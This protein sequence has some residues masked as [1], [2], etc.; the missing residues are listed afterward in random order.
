MSKKLI[1]VLVIIIALAGVG[2]Y[3]RDNISGIVGGGQEARF[4]NTAQAR[5][6]AQAAPETTTIRPA[7]NSSQVSAAGNIEIANQLPAVLQLEGLVAEVLVEV[8]DEVSAGDL[9]VALDTTD[10]ERA[11]QR[12]ELEFDVRQ[13]Q[14]DKLMEPSDVADIAAARANLASAKENLDEV[15]AGPTDSEIAAAEASLAAAQERYQEL[16]DGQS[17]AELIQVSVELHKA[18]LTLQQA[19]EAYDEIAYRDDI[20]SS[21]QAMDLQNATIDYEA[22]KAAYE[23]A[24]EPA[25][26]AD[27]QDALKSIRE[28]EQ[29][30]D[31][32]LNQP[33]D[34]EIAEAEAKVVSTEAELAGLLSGPSASDVREAELNLQQAQ[35]DLE[36]A[37]ANLDKARLRAPIAGTILAV[38]V[39][40][41]QKISGGLEALSLA[42][43][44]ELELTVNVAEV[45]VRKVREGQPAKITI[46]A[47][48]DDLFSGVVS[49]IAPSS[50]SE[51]GVVNYPV[52][53]RLDAANLEGV[54]PGMTAVTTIADGIN[55]AEWLVPTNALREFEGETMVVV[56]RNGQRN[57]VK[58]EPGSSQGEW[59]VVQSPKLKTGDEV[60]GQVSTFINDEEQIRGRGPFGPPRR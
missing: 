34:A 21:S 12:A 18:T 60:V 24:T 45:D 7:A 51:G 56:V 58:V 40:P 22:A 53:I 15:K 44:T 50:E 29:Q 20:G 25:S 49:R 9:L 17:E 23:V 54:R 38:D 35:V 28:A 5:D 30:L 43:L 32:L 37:E 19:Q 59:T 52:T 55:E 16:L 36:E 41:G 46:D 1:W 4:T 2:Y 6:G 47:L 48:P 27:L 3:F 31:S 11:I 10:L 13:A 26:P 39:Q 33:S 8:G 42:D 14:L 57:R